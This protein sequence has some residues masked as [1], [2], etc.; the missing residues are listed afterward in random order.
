MLGLDGRGNAALFADYLQWEQWRAATSIP[1]APKPVASQ[2]AKAAMPAPAKKKL[3][4]IEQREFDGIDAE[5]QAADQRLAA[6]KQR[7]EDPAV[8]IDPAA[9]TDALAE[10]EAAQAEHDRIL[11]RW[12][13][14]SEKAG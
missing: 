14:L 2:P 9:L 5:I 6:A 3:S 7:I 1:A 13:E 12:V 4:Y 11:E 8:A 10:L